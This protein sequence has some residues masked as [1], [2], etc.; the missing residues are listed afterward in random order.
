MTDESGELSLEFNEKLGLSSPSEGVEESSMEKGQIT[1]PKTQQTEPPIPAPPKPDTKLTTTSTAP[2]L[3]PHMLQSTADRLADISQTPLFLTSLDPT[4]SQSNPGLEA[5]QAL[6]YEGPAW[7]IAQNFREQGNECFRAKRWGDAREFY[8]KALGALGEARK[9]REAEGEGKEG[10][11]E[12]ISKETEIEEVCLVNRAACNLELKNYRQTSQDCTLALSLNPHNLKAHYRLALA[13]F[14]LSHH[15]Q[16]L[17]QTAQ[18]LALFPANTALLSLQAKVE[19]ALRLA[20]DKQNAL[21]A[22]Q[23]AQRAQA[24]RVQ[25]ALRAKGIR[26]R[27]TGT[28]PLLPAPNPG[29][30]F[31]AVP[32]TSDTL[33]FPTLLLYPLALQSDFLTALAEDEPL[34]PRLHDVLPPPWDTATPTPEYTPQAVALYMETVSGG[35]LKLGKNIPIGKV[36]GAGKVEVVDG[37]VRVFVLPRDKAEGWIEEFR[38]GRGRGEKS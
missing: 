16:A 2:A 7:E 5:L 15:T 34:L 14:S 28:P 29:I 18:G 1:P 30:A 36:L 12:E 31:R 8:G 33:T 35:L 32:P 25:A 19:S 24:L 6:A 10:G 23:A 9:K 4:A 37:V 26:T 13:S 21:A 22:A 38:E 3:P 20:A 11:R 27:S 17:A